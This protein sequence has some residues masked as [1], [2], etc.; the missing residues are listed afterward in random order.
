VRLG[1]AGGVE[2]SANGKPIGPVGEKGQVKI[3]EFKG[4]GFRVVPLSK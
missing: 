3:V 1:N 2:I 4:D